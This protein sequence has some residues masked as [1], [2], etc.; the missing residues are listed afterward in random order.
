[1]GKQGLPETKRKSEQGQRKVDAKKTSQQQQLDV[2]ANAEAAKRKIEEIKKRLRDEEKLR[3]VGVEAPKGIEKG[4]K[5]NR[6]KQHKHDEVAIKEDAEKDKK[7]L[8][9][10][11][12]KKA[13]LEVQRRVLELERKAEQKRRTAMEEADAKRKKAE[14]LKRI[15]RDQPSMADTDDKQQD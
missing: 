13:E 6:P 3:K 2:P 8:R 12:K 9:E 7:R 15:Q 14:V 4:E 5:K 1:M 11:A 10:E